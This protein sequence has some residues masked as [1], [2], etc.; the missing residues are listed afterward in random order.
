MKRRSAASF[1]LAA[2]LL[3]PAL[4]VALP[5]LEQFQ[6]VGTPSENLIATVSVPATSP[7][8]VS[9][10]I[11]ATDREYRLQVTNTWKYAGAVCT[12]ADTAYTTT[13]C[14]ATRNRT[15]HGLVIDGVRQADT[16]LTFR[17]DHVYSIPV[18][19]EGRSLLMQIWDT[20]YTDNT[21][22]L[23]VQVY[24]V[25]RVTYE[26]RDVRPL[27]PAYVNQE[28]IPATTYTPPGVPT[29]TVQPTNGIT[30]PQVGSLDFFHNAQGLWCISITTSSGTQPVGCV[31]DPGRVLPGGQNRLPDTTVPIGGQTVPVPVPICQAGCP[32]PGIQPAPIPIPGVRVEAGIPPGSTVEVILSWSADLSHLYLAA[33]DTAL[34]LG[35]LTAP[36]NFRSPTETAWFLANVQ[37]L[38]AT[39]QIGVKR[40]DGTYIDR[41]RV[42]AP[43]MGQF[44]E[45][46][47]ASKLLGL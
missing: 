45:A 1:V 11:L 34:G 8:T 4:A 35:S 36:W 14:W 3:V 47:F 31:I 39:F 32:I 2:I 43:G 6:R 29:Q 25:A 18:T 20:N 9:T 16:G 5:R 12:L 13:D 30:V 19:G 21:D 27:P 46:M 26:F 33:S 7:T 28:V 23:T 10:P 17:S 41:R 24:Q 38:G 44:I 42:D 40:A 37:N 22:G 15:G